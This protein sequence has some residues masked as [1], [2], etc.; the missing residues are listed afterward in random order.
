[1]NRSFFPIVFLSVLLLNAAFAPAQ[2]E[3][4]LATAA[5]RSFTP[6]DLPPAARQAY[7]GR[8]TL[9]ADTR[10]QELEL[11]VNDVLLE[12]EAK[13]RKLTV[14]KLVETGVSNRVPGP[15]EE[16]IKAVYD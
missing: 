15:T 8:K 3:Q 10:L 1:M 14:D 16:Q 2:T 7:D 9:V 4:V 11:T 12:E 6:D 5:G 13:L